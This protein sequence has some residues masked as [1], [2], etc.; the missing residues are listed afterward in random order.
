MAVFSFFNT[1]LSA[2]INHFSFA[3]VLAQDSLAGFNEPAVQQIA[4]KE[5]IFGLA[6]QNLLAQ[7]KRS[8]VNLKYKLY[9]T[10]QGASPMLSFSNAKPIGGGMGAV[11]NASPCVN[12]GFESNS[13]NG[14]STGSGFNLTNSCATVVTTGTNPVLAVMSTP[15]TDAVIGTVPNSPF[16]GSKVLKINDDI[17]DWGV[18]RISQTFPVTTA[19]FLYE[20]AYMAVMATQ[21]SC[22]EQTYMQVKLYNFQGTPLSCPLFT[23]APPP[24][25]GPTCSSPGI[26]WTSTTSGGLNVAYNASWQ[27]Y[28]ID[29][30]NYM[31]QNVTIEVTVADCIYGGHWGYSYFDSNCNQLGFTL[32]GST[33]VTA[34]SQ[35]VNLAGQCSQTATI[36]APFGLAP[37]SW[38][39]PSFTSTNQTISTGVPGN[40]TLSMNPAGSCLP[41][42]RIVNLTF[43]PPTTITASSSNLC[44]SGTNTAATLTAVGASAYTWQ[45][46]GSTSSVIVVSPASTTIYTVTAQTGTCVGTYTTLITVNTDPNVSTLAST[47][48]VCPGESATIT[49]LGASSYVWNPGGMTGSIIVV[50]PVS[51]TSYTTIGTSTAGCTGSFV[52]TINV[53]SPLTLTL[54]TF[55][56]PS[57]CI[58]G[59]PVTVVAGGATTFTWLPGGSN[60]FFQSL[61]PTVTTQYTVIGA[62]GACTATANIT[63]TVDPGPSITITPNPTI[64]CPGNT[65][66]LTATSAAAVGSFT[67]APGASNAAAITVTNALAGGYSVSAVNSNGCRSTFT[68]NP[69]LSPVPVINVT[70]A[71]PSVCA[72]GSIT[73]S[74]TGAVNYTWTPTGQTG[75]SAVF[76]PSAT[77]TYTVLGENGAGCIGQTTVSIVVVPIPVINASASPTAICAGSCATIIPGGASTYTISGGSFIVCPSSNA[78]F[79]VTGSSA[80]GCVSNP[81]NVPVVVNSLPVITASANPA[82]FCAGSSSTLT[83]SGGINYLWS[84]GTVG[85]VDVVSPPSNQTFTVTGDNAFGCSNSTVVAVTVIPLPAISI[86]PA[87]STIC[88]GGS[89]S[90]LAS[91]ATNYTWMPG[92]ITGANPT[93]NPASSTIYTVT[94]ANG[95][96]TGQTLYPVTVAPAPVITATYVPGTI[97]AGDCATLSTTGAAT[98]FIVT[99]LSPVACPTITTNYTVVGVSIDGCLSNTVT[100]TLFVNNPP[101]LFATANPTA[102]CPGDSSLVS[103]SGAVTYTWLP[104]GITTNSFYAKPGSTT[105]YTVSGTNASGCA[106]TTTT[107][108]VVNPIPVV[109]VTPSATTICPGDPVTLTANGASTY[110][111]V[112]N[113]PGITL[114]DF[115]SATTVYTVVGSIGT[116]TGM[117]T[118]TVTVAPSPVI[119]ASFNPPSICAGSCATLV[120]TGAASY[121]ITGLSG[122]DC[123]AITTNYTVVG[124]SSFGCNSLPVVGTL[125]V[126]PAPNISASASPTVICAGDITTIS[127]SGGVSYSF[128]PGNATGLT[129]VDTPSVTTNYSVT[130]TDASGCTNTAAVTVSVNSIPTVFAIATPTAI[131]SGD[132]AVLNAAGGTTYSW[133]PGFL[134]GASVTVSPVVTT[135][136][137]VTAFNGIC[138]NSTTVQLDVDIAPTVSITAS[139]LTMCTGGSVSVFLSGAASYSW[140]DGATGA[141]RV[142]TPSVTTTY[143]ITGFSAN[144]CA[145]LPASIT[146]TVNPAPTISASA[147]P[148][149]ICA[150]GSSNL[151]ATG[152]LNYLWMPVNVTGASINVSP[153]VTTVYQVTGTDAFGC[154]ATD[155]VTVTVSPALAITAAA[156]QSAICSG[157]STTLSATAGATSYS[158]LPTSLTGSVIILVPAVSTVY[159]LVATNGACTTQVTVPVV[160][161]SS[162]SVNVSSTSASLCAG[163]CATLTAT[164]ASS[165]TWSDGSTGPVT[166]VCPSVTTSYSVIGGAG[167]CT[168]SAQTLIVVSSIPNL[169]IS[170]TQNTLCPSNPATLTASGALTYSWSTGSTNSIIVVAPLSTTI[171]TLVGFNSICSSVLQ[172]TQTVVAPGN[173]SIVASSPSI[174]AGFTVGLLAVGAVGNYTWQ[175]GT[176]VGN[177]Y[178][179]S[180]TSTTTYTAELNNGGCPTTATVTVFVNPLPTVN[181]SA[182]PSSVCVGGT[183]TVTA[184]GAVTYSWIPSLVGGNTFTDAPSVATTYTVVGFDAVGCPNA[185]TITVGI[186]NPAALTASASANKICSGSPVSLT[187]SGSTNYTWSP[188]GQTGASII[189]N[190]TSTTVYTVSGGNAGCLGTATVLVNVD[191]LP[192]IVATA[193]SPSICPGSTVQLNATGAVNYTWNPTG[194]SGQQITDIPAASTNY[195]VTG[196]DANGCTGTSNVFVFVNPLTNILALA[197]P[198]NICAGDSS[199]LTASGGLSYTWNPGGQTTSTLVVNPSATTIYTLLANDVSGCTGAFSVVVNVTPIPTLNVSPLN[200]SICIGSTATLTASGAGNYTWLPS[201]TTSSVTFENPTVPT[202]YTVIGDINGICAVSQTVTVFVNPLP[203]NVAAVSSGTVSCTSP[204]AQL[205]GLSTTT[206]VSY[207]WAN[208]TFSVAGQNPVISGVWGVFTLSVIDNVTGCVATATVN[209][210]TD[211]SIPLVTAT[212]SG[213]ITCAVPSV[214]LNAANTTALPGYSW[215]GPSAFTS[216]VQSPVVTAQGSYTII[217]TDLTSLCTGSAVVYVTTHTTVAMTASIS[218]ATCNS[219]GGSNNDGSIS[220]SG[221]TLTDKYDLVSGATY[222]GTATYANAAS[223][224]VGGVITNNLSNPT[225]TL[226]YTLRLFDIEGCTKDTTL[227]LIPVNCSLPSFGIAKAVSV[228]QVNSDGSYNLT[229]TVVLKNYS[230]AVLNVQNVVENLSATFP[231]PTS[232]TVI[233]S[234]MRISGNSGISLNSAAF[235]GSSQTNLITGV[236]NPLAGGASDTI[237]FDVRVKTL[238]FFTNFKNTITGLAA[239][240]NN[241]MIADSSNAGLD[242]DKNSPTDVADG[243]PTN[244]NVATS[245]MFEPNKFFGITKAGEI[246]KSDN[247]SYDITYTITVHNLGNDTVRDVILKDSLFEMAIRNPVTYSIRSGPISLGGGLVGNS[248][249]DGKTDINLVTPLASKIAP[250]TTS[251]LYFIINVVPGTVTAISNSAYGSGVVASGLTSTMVLS[252]TSNAGSNP[253]A[254]NNGVWNEASDNVPTVLLISNTHT[255]FIPEGFSPDGDANNQYF[256]I[257]GLSE[258]GNN[259]LTVFNRWG[260]KVYSS[261]NYDNTWDGTPN[262]SGTIGKDK[263][264]PGTYY[265]ILEMKGSGQKAITGFVVLQY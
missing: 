43:P 109:G 145:G 62:S 65:T 93:F 192:T 118:A 253:D 166:V 23:F 130:G 51:T 34:P 199:T 249:Y 98:N 168:N 60:I 45:P 214:T 108:V 240:I 31:N 71:S 152:G 32:N 143:F 28:S 127:G 201:G 243:N 29:L 105:I 59:T 142:L 7:K 52:T 19:N 140:S 10:P 15:F 53:S 1:D 21:H 248:S 233:P 208:S 69:N 259:S 91:G 129:F 100:G 241:I 224:P 106:G 175:P 213:S 215:S 70:P 206:N 48:S 193:S 144:G 97:C 107:E 115:P 210:P 186:I 176:F 202:T 177:P 216:T 146:I 22:C 180:P 82:S 41:I 132:V 64:T 156:S 17:A 204:T 256:V 104:G 153:S 26:A 63:V 196:T 124:I 170:G 262:V 102:I 244:N 4:L 134:S 161:N 78:T 239:D 92:N 103:A 252:D 219:V 112:P 247:D 238:V 121:S 8:Y 25:S 245:V 184:S 159:T 49:A 38:T 24:P 198:S 9:S 135:I 226:A 27:N 265:Y 167:S 67:W 18:T 190:P 229:Y 183:V 16:T 119:T 212:T 217:V 155:N 95:A 40:Y 79:T 203:A 194:Q 222:T 133:S 126:L 185:D 237:I 218:A 173:F 61:S 187:A 30:T 254:N 227:Y 42:T 81:I 225:T 20:F 13:L 86:S 209:V 5:G 169:S 220:V 235:D 37:Y 174:C 223:V 101:T 246:H 163:S 110:T 171:Y 89:V 258:L 154:S 250:N 3:P 189:E 47:F 150:G 87:A 36:T 85:A 131:C 50:T 211:N 172:Y 33:F 263:L 162:I 56:T 157:N 117:A 165:Y 128:Q 94:G 11:I 58:G 251:S 74:A 138:S 80:N 260:N 84:D 6:Y 236:A 83:A 231:A 160:V 116:C 139:S 2:Q 255:L 197:S 136:Y 73:L 188:G 90:P 137:T 179:D 125:T 191:L 14:W 68:S 158:W 261:S 12:E 99:G 44:S 264:P 123:P 234:S 195:T 113:L 151:T 164:G 57:L 88:P 72:G 257:Q 46:G 55:A 39:G 141:V 181:L 120:A 221:F 122:V 207:F 77:T 182:N 200:S 66:T 230:N 228:P 232:F 148:T 149:N 178:V 54:Q 111:W 242:P 205:F 96:C 75:A 76:T 35:T 114:I 147:S